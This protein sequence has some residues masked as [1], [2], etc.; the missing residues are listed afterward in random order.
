[1]EKETAIRLACSYFNYKWPKQLTSGIMFYNGFRITIK[2]FNELA[3][4]FK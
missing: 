3:K 2:E 1:M 4:D